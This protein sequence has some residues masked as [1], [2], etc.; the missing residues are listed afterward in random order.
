[1]SE[2]NKGNLTAQ[3]YKD[4]ALES[5]VRAYKSLGGSVRDYSYFEQK[6][7]DYI[8]GGADY[9]K[10]NDLLNGELNKALDEEKKGF[11]D[12]QPK[13]LGDFYKN[14]FKGNEEIIGNISNNGLPPLFTRIVF[15]GIGAILIFWGVK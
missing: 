7:N 10:A 4:M 13:T 9:F 14:I 11:L 2:N 3:D 15:V 1:M 12:S 8:N 5:A 6:Y